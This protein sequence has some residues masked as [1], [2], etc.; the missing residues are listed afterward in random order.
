M[1][2][3]ITGA[4]KPSQAAK[5]LPLPPP[6]DL[7]AQGEVM[8]KV[9]EQHP[10]MSVFHTNET[11]IV[12]RSPSPPPSPSVHNKKNMFKRMSRAPMKEDS[13]G[14]RGGSLFA[15][16]STISKKGNGLNATN[17]NGEPDHSWC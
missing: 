4:L 7:S 10:N 12:D 9:F 8:N 6:K 5:E 16:P 11:G 2:A 14:N 15:Q 13:D 3:K 1:W 17:M